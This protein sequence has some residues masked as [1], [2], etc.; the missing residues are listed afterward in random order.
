MRSNSRAPAEVVFLVVHIGLNWAPFDNKVSHFSLKNLPL[1]I[2]RGG[3]SRLPHLNHD[4]APPPVDSFD[5]TT[6]A[7]SHDPVLREYL[8]RLGSAG[9]WFRLIFLNTKII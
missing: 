2:F 9:E 1:Q 3:P 5:P 6:G 4:S 8:E 7:Y